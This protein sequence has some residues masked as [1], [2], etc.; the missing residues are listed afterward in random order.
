M[1][2]I[3]SLFACTLLIPLLGVAI[4]AQAQERKQP[5]TQGQAAPRQDQAEA[6][7]RTKCFEEA[8]AAAARV[9]SSAGQAQ[10]SERNAVGSDAYH[11]CA[12]REGTRP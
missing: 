1:L 8:N 4:P 10:A 12:M 9:T 5:Q 3:K 7:K 11:Q 2:S 6:A